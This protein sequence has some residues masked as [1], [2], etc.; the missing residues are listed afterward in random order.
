LLASFS[1]CT[2]LRL[3]VL[4]VLSV[5][6][7][8]LIGHLVAKHLVSGVTMALQTLPAFIGLTYESNTILLL[9]K[10]FSSCILN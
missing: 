6:L 4:N 10:G 1:S 8:V 7:A 2:L 9:I 3:L 5:N